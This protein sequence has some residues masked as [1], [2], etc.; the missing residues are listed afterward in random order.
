MT[1]NNE[2]QKGDLVIYSSDDGKITI[3]VRIEDENVWLTQQLMADL[4]Q[5]TPQNITLHIK[6]IYDDGELLEPATCKD[7]LQV[8][9]ERKRQ[10]QRMLKYYNPDMMMTKRYVNILK[11]DDEPFY[12]RLK[13][14]K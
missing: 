10:T 14:P 8:R 11:N 2:P 9:F 3:E 6:S 13:R 7:Y 5:T 1:E 4:F 12:R